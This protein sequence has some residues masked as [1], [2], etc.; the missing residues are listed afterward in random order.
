MSVIHAHDSFCQGGHQF[1][2]MS[3]ELRTLL[4][5][6]SKWLLI[7]VQV[8]LL[9]YG[10]SQEQLIKA[11]T[12]RAYTQCGKC[13]WVVGSGPSLLWVT[14]QSSSDFY[15]DW[16]PRAQNITQYVISLGM[17]KILSNRR[18]HICES[19]L[20]ILVTAQNGRLAR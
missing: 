18:N 20:R 4:Q 10:P 14:I 16:F 8:S 13:Y 7:S 9:C 5:S 17:R 3:W 19:F 1:S 6:Y 15:R 12:I 2:G 11:Q